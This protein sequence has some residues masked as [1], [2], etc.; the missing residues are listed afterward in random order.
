MDAIIS[1]RAGVAI[2]LGSECQC[3]RATGETTP[4]RAEDV[5][6]LIRGYP[7][8]RALEDLTFDAIQSELNLEVSSDES[9]HLTLILLDACRSRDIKG[10]AA[11]ELDVLLRTER[12]RHKIECILHA[13]PLS[14]DAD[15]RG[16]IQIC[17]EVEA[18][19]TAA[20]IS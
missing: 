13:R 14:E 16:A 10:E 19:L 15:L 11:A 1:G 6:L 2:L 18:R 3:L 12:V 9:L 20:F 17:D 7:D 5:P 8:I 4:I